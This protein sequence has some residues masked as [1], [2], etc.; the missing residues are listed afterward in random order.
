MQSIFLK[1]VF[2]PHLLFY[3]FTKNM[4]ALKGEREFA[5]LVRVSYIKRRKIEELS[6]KEKRCCSCYF[7]KRIVLEFNLNDSAVR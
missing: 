2:L 3:Y 6:E 1:I 5:S 4:S 7:S